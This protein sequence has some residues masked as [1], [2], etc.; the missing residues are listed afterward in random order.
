MSRVKS[1][2]TTPEIFLRKALWKRGIRYRIAPKNIPGKPD[3]CLLK[4]KLA[5]FCDGGFWHGRYFSEESKLPKTN[6]EFWKRKIIRNME[7]DRKTDEILK[8]EGWTVLRFWDEDIVKNTDA[9]VKLILESI[10]TN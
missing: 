5:I 7:R 10:T 8:N 1:R 6:V 3:I 2:D 9:I 4:A